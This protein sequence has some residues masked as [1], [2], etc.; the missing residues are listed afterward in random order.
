MIET[1]EE[2]PVKQISPE[3]QQVGYTPQ[4]IEKIVQTA[5]EFKF[6]YEKLK[7]EPLPTFEEMM[8]HDMLEGRPSSMET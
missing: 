8:L 6:P 1:L 3:E 4:E 2:A 5:N 7:E